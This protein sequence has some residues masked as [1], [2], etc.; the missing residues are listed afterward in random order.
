MSRPPCGDHGPRRENASAVDLLILSIFCAG[1]AGAI[2]AA[3]WVI[4]AAT[5]AFVG[6]S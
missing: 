1:A 4:E 5:A 6:G 3:V 2:V